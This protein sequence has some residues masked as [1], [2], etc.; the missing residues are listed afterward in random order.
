MNRKPR[1]KL[2]KFTRFANALLPHEVQHLMLVHHFEDVEKQKILEIIHHN[3]GNLSQKKNFD[4]NIDKRK[5]SAL[6]L[7][8]DDKLRAIDADTFFEWLSLTDKEI[9]TD[10]ITPAGEK[11]IINV[12]KNY[13]FPGYYFIRFYELVQNYRSY[14]LIRM[15]HNYLKITSRFLE[16]YFDAYHT[17]KEINQR[18]HEA[19]TDIVDQ[20]ATQS[21]DARHWENWLI[22]VFKDENLDGLNRY[23]A[24][25]RLTFLYYNYKE[26]SKLIELF[27]M[28][29]HMIIRG[30]IYSR[31][32]LVNYYANRLMVHSRFNEPDIAEHFGYLSIRHKG[33]D[34]LQYANNLCAVLL[35][36]GKISEAFHLMQS[37][38]P[39][40][41]NTMS[42]HN[43]IG[44]A[45]YYMQTLNKTGKA[46]EAFSYGKSFLDVNRSEIMEQRWHL[47]F[48]TMLQSLFL[49]ERYRE[50]LSMVRK[51]GLLEKETNYRN[52]PGYIP[53]FIWLY[54]IARYM[55][56]EINHEQLQSAF[57]STIAP[58]LNDAHK[59]RILLEFAEEVNQKIPLINMA[60]L[61]VGS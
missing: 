12:L 27:N 43:R 9:M 11:Q 23:Y 60:E 17:S 25:V 8:I 59:I 4:A 44:F 35:R 42:A 16:K 29:D 47:F 5:Y 53:T 49:L 50:M 18:L 2:L 24:I 26:Y 33:A 55:E 1:G 37:S 54:N 10:S 61:M 31:R 15:R 7:W 20:Y 22:S 45:A 30:E 58:C 6:M 52:R 19:T 39:E 46:S 32:I 57:A 14:L 28:L 34:Y 41:K 36:N 56:L 40:L 13:R 3:A 21:K 48:T 38:F 51:F